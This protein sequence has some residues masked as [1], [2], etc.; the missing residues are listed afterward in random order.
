MKLTGGMTLI[1][2]MIATAIGCFLMAGAMSLFSSARAS[3]RAT[4][5]LAR[6]QETLRF[7]H[8]VLHADLQLAGFPAT[9][10]SPHSVR[11]NGRDVTAWA[12]D[13]TR[14][15]EIHPDPG[16]PPCPGVKPTPESEMLIVRHGNPQL[17]AGGRDM[18]YTVNGYYV[19]SLSKY[20]ARRPALRRR[21]LVGGVMHDEEIIAGISKLSA[22]LGIDTDGDG[23]ADIKIDANEYAEKGHAVH[24][25][26]IIIVELTLEA[27]PE[28]HQADKPLRFR[29]ATTTRSVV[30]RNLSAIK[31]P[32]HE[33]P[34]I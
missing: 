25:G 29:S 13:R 8:R 5:S 14:P 27:F 24:A 2:L 17:T 12:L 31:P 21:S 6:Q 15:V 20:D 28:L 33:S 3:Y 19:S 16:T 4:E 26:R 32:S 11:C 22:R 30:L 23:L 34:S 18:N 1:E 7:A 9:P 10:N